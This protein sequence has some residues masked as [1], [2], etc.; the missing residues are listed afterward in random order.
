MNSK[1]TDREIL[2]DMLVSQK[3]ATGV[4]NTCAY[5]CAN[6]TLKGQ[7]MSILSEEQDLA[8]DVFKDMQNRGW[9]SPAAA[10]SSKINQVRSKFESVAG[11]ISGWN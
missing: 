6:P 4:Y 9:Y 2:G 5:E 11:E 1:I 7:F 8:F 10:E 3:H